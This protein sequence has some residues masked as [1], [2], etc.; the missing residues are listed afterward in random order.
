MSIKYPG[1]TLQTEDSLLYRSNTRYGC[2][3]SLARYGLSIL[4]LRGDGG[5][6]HH[7]RSTKLRLAHQLVIGRL[8]VFPEKF[9]FLTF[10]KIP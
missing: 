3:L 10:F 1:D 8:V 2:W 9:R 6:N 4:F 5:M 7:I